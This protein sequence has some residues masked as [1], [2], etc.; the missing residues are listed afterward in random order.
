MDR[1]GGELTPLRALVAAALL[2]AAVEMPAEA[3]IRVSPR[4]LPRPP[5]FR[6]AINA[7]I[8]DVKPFTETQTFDQYFEQASFTLTRTMER[9][10][11]YDG[12]IS[13][14]VWK[15][16][17]VIGAF[18]FL[19][20]TGPGELTASVPHP[21]MFSTPRSVT[22]E[23][24]Q[25]QRREMGYHI[26]LGWRVAPT[27]NLEFTV[28]GGPSIFVADQVLVTGLRLGLA[29]EVYPFDTLAFPAVDTESQ[30][31]TVTGY[32]A[33][34]DMTW[35]F[36]RRFGLGVLLRYAVGKKDFTPP[37]GQP[38]EVEVGGLQAGG[39]LRVVF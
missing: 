31:Q 15:R 10:V 9:P 17:H 27:P 23:V 39:G 22:G 12:S 4:P 13:V 14:G 5:R 2:A 1:G 18:S 32:N 16:L 28:F 37:G 3:Q 26:D 38:I 6:V 33:G 34:V 11:F 35:R 20:N 30:T 7:G 29:N 24:S 21:L 8:Q 36:T 25:V 19:T